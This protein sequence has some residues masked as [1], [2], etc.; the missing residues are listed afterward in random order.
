MSRVEVVECVGSVVSTFQQAAEGVEILK[1]RVEKRKKK[2][3]KDIEELVEIRVLHRSLVD[4]AKQCRSASED[5]QREFGSSFS[6]GDHIATTS[7]K[8]GTRHSLVD[9][10]AK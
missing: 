5:R 3:E 1:A 6:I 9:M 8:V 4:G 7:L 10:A 2:K